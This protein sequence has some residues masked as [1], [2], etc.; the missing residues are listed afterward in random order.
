MSC[1]PSVRCN[2]TSSWSGGKPIWMLQALDWLS[3]CAGVGAP[4]GEWFGTLRALAAARCSDGYSLLC[5][6][7]H[8]G[9]GGCCR[10][11]Q[12]CSD[13]SGPGKLRVQEWAL[14]AEH[15]ILKEY[16]QSCGLGVT[17][18]EEPILHR[19]LMDGLRCRS[20][21]GDHKLRRYEWIG[22]GVQYFHDCHYDGYST[23]GILMGL[24]ESIR[25]RQDPCFIRLAEPYLQGIASQIAD[26]NR[27]VGWPG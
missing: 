8:S 19:Q 25:D 16:Q 14:Y 21:P 23:F 15:H 6:R 12:H 1:E 13:A 20:E 9:H 17:V 11:R 5:P 3:Q 24:R 7:D 10:G 27:C 26:Y 2:M 22:A 4:H 18:M